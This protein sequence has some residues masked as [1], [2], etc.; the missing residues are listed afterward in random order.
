MGLTY[1]LGL[2]DLV[3]SPAIPSNTARSGYVYPVMMSVVRD[4]GSDP[5]DKTTHRRLGSYLALTTYNL[6]LAV[7]VIFFTGAAP[8]AMSSRLA[9]SAG[10]TV[11]WPGWFTAAVVPG[12]IG[13][14][15]VPLV[16]YA[17]NRPEIRRTPDAAEMTARELRRLG[18]VTRHEWVTLGV[19]IG[20]IVLWVIGDSFMSATTVALLGLGALLLSGALTW[21]QRLRGTGRLVAHRARGGRGPPAHL[22][23]GWAAVV[24]PDRRVV[25]S[26]AGVQH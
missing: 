22:A 13:V 18:P 15:A 12:L 8:N 23:G 7:S 26:E 20:M 14:I 1:G 11:N 10:V 17:L 4:F 9:E 6:N 21:E 19:F 16:I 24:E 25:K 5:D 3:T 2:A